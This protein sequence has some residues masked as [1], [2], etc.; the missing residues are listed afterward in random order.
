MNEAKTFETVEEYALHI[1]AS[2]LKLIVKIERNPKA[3]E[4]LTEHLINEASD[5]IQSAK[6]KREVEAGFDIS[7]L[8]KPKDLTPTE[9]VESPLYGE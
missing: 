3:A 6:M 4:S 7:T 9:D 5:L 1:Q 8:P 2:L